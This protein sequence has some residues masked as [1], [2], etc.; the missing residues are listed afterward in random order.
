MTDPRMERLEERREANV[1]KQ[2]DN[3]K[4]PA[5][6]AMYYYCRGCGVQVAVLPEGWWENPPPKHC[7]DCKLLVEAGL[8]D[9]SDS[10]RTWVAAHRKAEAHG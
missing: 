3:G 8:L 5:G 4:L 2:V 6:S 9:S 1:G 7:D 10:F